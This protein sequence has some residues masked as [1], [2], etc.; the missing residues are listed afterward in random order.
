MGRFDFVIAQAIQPVFGAAPLSTQKLE[1]LAERAGLPACIVENTSGFV[2]LSATESFLNSVQFDVGDSTFLFDSLG[3]DIAEKRASHSVVGVPLPT[4]VTGKE[5]LQSMTATF[6]CF[7]SGARF[8]CE[9]QG[10]LFWVVRTTSATEWSNEWSVLQYNLSIMISG[11]CRLFGR[12]VRPIAL[13]LPEARSQDELP[14]DIRDLPIILDRNRFGIALSVASVASAGFVLQG[15]EKTAIE[16]RTEPLTGTMLQELATCLAKFVTSPT[17]D[18]LSERVAHAFGLSTRSYR[19]HL[20]NFGMS[21]SRLL[22]DVRLDLALTLLKDDLLSI[23]EIAFELG[24]AHSGDFTRFFKD[25]MGCSPLEFRR[26][27]LQA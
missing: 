27:R 10:N 5:A 16:H 23:T 25:R 2:P 24:Y 13:C 8:S 6:N 22:S 21:H 11:A 9:R 20:A 14:E 19:R 17:S 18:K 3:L 1:S 4:G 12:K 26:L 15:P 7:I